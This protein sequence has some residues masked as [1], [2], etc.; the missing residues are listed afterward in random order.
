M[1]ARESSSKVHAKH[2]TYTHLTQLKASYRS[3]F[4]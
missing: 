1:A 3:T 4:Y 2:K